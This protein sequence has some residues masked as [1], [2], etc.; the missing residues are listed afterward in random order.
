MRA[1]L[2]L[3]KWE[4]LREVDRGR[5]GELVAEADCSVQGVVLLHDRPAL[6]GLCAFEAAQGCDDRRP[7]DGQGQGAE[8]L[9]GLE[10]PDPEGSQ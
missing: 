7:N 10:G 5:L 6:E 9:R 3:Q 2:Q 4:I 8:R 1:L